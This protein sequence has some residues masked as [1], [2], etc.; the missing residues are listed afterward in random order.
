MLTGLRTTFNA[1]KQ[2][3]NKGEKLILPKLKTFFKDDSISQLD[4]FNKNDFIGSDGNSYEL[5]TRRVSRNQYRTTFMPVNKVIADKTQYFIFSF[6]DGKDCYIKY[7]DQKFSKYKTEMLIDARS[8]RNGLKK[9][10]YHIPV[11]DLTD[12]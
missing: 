1:D 5:K 4:E 9:L 12:F 2:L 6:C 8:G 10:H 11:E 3:G 7:D